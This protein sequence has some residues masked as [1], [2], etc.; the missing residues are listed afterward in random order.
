[1]KQALIIYFFRRKFVIQFSSKSSRKKGAAIVGVI[2]IATWC[3]GERL[4]LL[5]LLFQCERS[6]WEVNIEFEALI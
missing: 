2:L 3:H 1:M 6:G 4:K 5:F